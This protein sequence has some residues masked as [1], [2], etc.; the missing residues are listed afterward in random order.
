MEIDSLWPDYI[1]KFYSGLGNR[2]VRHGISITNQQHS[3]LC[4]E[5]RLSANV[6]KINEMF[7]VYFRTVRGYKTAHEW[8]V[9][10]KNIWLF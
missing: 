2:N 5:S 7:P 3:S 4:M 10:S 1:Y 9:E 6:I 8:V